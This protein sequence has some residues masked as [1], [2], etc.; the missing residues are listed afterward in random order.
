MAEAN[1]SLVLQAMG[2]P[3]HH[4]ARVRQVH[5][6]QVVELHAD[7]HQV[8]TES[9]V[10]E[11]DGLVSD[12]PSSALSVLVADCVPILIAF[13][14]GRTVGVIHAGWRGVVAGVIDRAVRALQVTFRTSPSDAVAAIG[15]CIGGE[16]FEV[17]HE[18]AEAFERVGLSDAIDRSRC[19]HPNGKP[20]IDLA[21][22]VRCQLLR[23]GFAPDAIDAADQCTFANSELFYSYRRDGEESGRQA[24]VIA[25]RHD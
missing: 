6:N 13:R 22:A 4:W 15:P 21:S 16:A 10:C 14:T 2:C 17:G 25:P 12:L 19:D 24:A 5:G 8:G 3:D 9:P 7:S 18:V 20:H 11:G 1:R 23:A